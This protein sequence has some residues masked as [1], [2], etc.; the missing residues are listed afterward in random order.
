MNN[1]R[2]RPSFSEDGS[3]IHYFREE[4]PSPNREESP[5]PRNKE[6][7]PILNNGERSSG[8]KRPHDGSG[9]GSSGSKRP[10]I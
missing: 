5:S 1:P 3:P 9:E 4:S 2:G 7:S 6:E 8:S 10:R